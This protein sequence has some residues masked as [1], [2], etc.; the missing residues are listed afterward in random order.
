MSPFTSTLLDRFN[1]QVLACQDEAFTLALFLLGDE[2][3][4]CEVV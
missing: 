4:V 3:A 2:T 1:Q